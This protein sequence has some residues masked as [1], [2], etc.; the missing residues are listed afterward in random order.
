M[1][2]AAVVFCSFLGV[3]QVFSDEEGPYPTL[4]VCME[5]AAVLEKESVAEFQSFHGASKSKRV[6][7]EYADP[8]V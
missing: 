3:C 1:F 6:C 2:W 5:R 4:A 8:D 7:A